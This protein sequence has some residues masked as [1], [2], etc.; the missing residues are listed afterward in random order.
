MNRVRVTLIYSSNTGA[1]LEQHGHTF[2]SM[3]RGSNTESCVSLLIFELDSC[4]VRKQDSRT[5]GRVLGYKG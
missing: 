5:F 2:V 3:G 4:A 1:E